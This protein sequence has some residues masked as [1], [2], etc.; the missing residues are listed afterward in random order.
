MDAL[1]LYRQGR[2]E[3]ALTLAQQQGDIKTAALAL[4]ALGRD[5]QAR[6]LLEAWQPT[7]EIPAAS[8]SSSRASPPSPEGGPRC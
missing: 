5:D 6:A 4:L 3:E 7:G 8:T 2:C 1:T